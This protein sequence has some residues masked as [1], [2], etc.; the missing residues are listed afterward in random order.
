MQSFS[1]DHIIPVDQGGE[2]IEE[3]LA[4]SCQGCNNHKYTKTEGYD[5]ITHRMVSLYHPRRHH[6]MEGFL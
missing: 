5:M 4:L 6:W 2:T 3:N 1:I